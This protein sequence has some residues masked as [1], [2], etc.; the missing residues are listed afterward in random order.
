MLSQ[1]GHDFFRR[2]D[3]D[4]NCGAESARLN[5]SCAFSML[6]CDASVAGSGV[7]NA[8]CGMLNIGQA[9]TAGST[10]TFVSCAMA[11][12]S[13]VWRYVTPDYV[14]RGTP[15]IAIRLE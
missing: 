13:V 14:E 9:A 5:A 8:Y 2:C 15:W 10:R 11:S 1:L 6:I 3:V 4:V 7:C 12:L